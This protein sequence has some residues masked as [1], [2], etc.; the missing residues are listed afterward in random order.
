LRFDS[1]STQQTESFKD[2]GRLQLIRRAMAGRE[3]SFALEMGGQ[4]VDSS[5]QCF[6]TEMIDKLF[7]QEPFRQEVGRPPQ[8]IFVMIDPSGAGQS[9]QFALIALYRDE[10]T[11]HVVVSFPSFFHWASGFGA[12]K[13]AFYYCHRGFVTR[14]RRRAHNSRC[15]RQL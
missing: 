8:Q 12:H 9:S 13:G 4:M 14:S 1:S 5:N 7:M 15:S 11:H 3:R 6:K 2:E 10:V